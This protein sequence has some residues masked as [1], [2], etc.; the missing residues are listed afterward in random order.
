MHFG[1]T[2]EEAASGGVTEYIQHHLT[3]LTVNLKP[4]GG[5]WALH[6]DSV[7]FNL[8]I[9]L[10]FILLFYIAA[11]RATSGVPG[12]FQAFAEV[13]LD[14]VNGLVKDAFHGNSKFIGPLALTIFCLVILDNF[15]DILPVDALP[16]VGH[17]LG[18][19]HLRT[20]AT[21]DV[22]TTIGMALGVFLLIQYMGIKHKGGGCSSR[23]GSPRRF[24]PT[25]SARW[26]SH[27]SISFCASLKRPCG[28]CLCRCGCSA[29]CMPASSYSC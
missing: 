27:P 19:E 17:A 5:F 20:V 23:N 1:M 6:L 10:I 16:A 12:K 28:L 8:A 9:A 15:M 2:V 29:T 25:A 24:M 14:W 21:A 26:R 3:H 22:N 7:I 13:M 4:E 11:H 18:V